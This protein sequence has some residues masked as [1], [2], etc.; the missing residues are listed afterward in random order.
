MNMSKIDEGIVILSEINAK[1]TFDRIMEDTG[2]DIPDEEINYY[3]NNFKID[4]F[5]V[6]IIRN[7]YASCFGNLRD[8]QNIGRR[9]FYKLTLTLKKYLISDEQY[10]PYKFHG[11]ECPLAYIL[12]GNMKGKLINRIIRNSNFNESLINNETFKYL[13]NTKYRHLSQLKPDD[14]NRLISSF[15]STGFTYVAYEKQEVT[16]EEIIYEDYKISDQ[17]LKFIRA[18]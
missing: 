4:P 1:T 3:L 9:D 10:N 17:L 8:I 6:M 16:N 2:F 13:T 15:V 14:L 11:E 7:F 12:T 5:Q 18:F